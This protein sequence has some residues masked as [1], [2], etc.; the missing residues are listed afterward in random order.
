M[1]RFWLSAM[2][3]L[4]LAPLLNGQEAP[5]SK[6]KE[7]LPEQAKRLGIKQPTKTMKF[8]TEKSSK[9]ED[10]YDIVVDEEE[11]RKAG[12]TPEELRKAMK[13]AMDSRSDRRE[14]G[15]ITIE[16]YDKKDDTDDGV[17]S[18]EDAT[19][20]ERNPNEKVESGDAQKTKRDA[21]EKRGRMVAKIK[22]KNPP[23]NPWTDSKKPA[24]K[25]YDI[26][27]GKIMRIR[28]EGACQDQNKALLE[29]VKFDNPT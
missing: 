2:L 3:F 20:E 17:N 29:A 9:Y 10:E 24:E 27:G 5:D 23:E 22:K 21:G 28:S 1:L 8:K 18:R 7:V 6:E 25:K 16:T 15:E 12:F 4:I 13:N 19:Q 26:P 14:N 11:A